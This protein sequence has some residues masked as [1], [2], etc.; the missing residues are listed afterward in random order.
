MKHPET[1]I[2]AAERLNIGRKK[3]IIMDFNGV[4]ELADGGHL[5]NYKQ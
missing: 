2:T 3:V 1:M 4:A 5:A